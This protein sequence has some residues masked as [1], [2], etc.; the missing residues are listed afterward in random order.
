LILG[1]S[2]GHQIV[3]LFYN[4]AILAVVETKFFEPVIEVFKE[5]LFAYL[6]PCQHRPTMPDLDESDTQRA[7]VR[8][9]ELGAVTGC[10]GMA[11]SR[12]AGGPRIVL[13]S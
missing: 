12:G 2:I 10:A 9:N 1:Y 11:V 4:L 7:V 6:H 8:F 13:G 3:S 5:L